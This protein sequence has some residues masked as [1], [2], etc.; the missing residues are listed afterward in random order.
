MQQLLQ[1][2]CPTPSLQKGHRC[3][4]RAF[5]IWKAKYRK[6]FSW[7]SK[8]RIIGPETNRTGFPSPQLLWLAYHKLSRHYQSLSFRPS[9]YNTTMLTFR[10]LHPCYQASAVVMSPDHG[11]S[12]FTLILSH[13]NGNP[14]HNCLIFGTSYGVNSLPVPSA[15]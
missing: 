7:L 2:E 15:V 8:Q 4:S 13:M 12:F 14:Q 9:L 1:G 10:P 5:R 3:L 11:R 6:I